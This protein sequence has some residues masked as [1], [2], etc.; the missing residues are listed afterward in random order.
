MRPSAHHCRACLDP[1]SQQRTGQV[2]S[3]PRAPNHTFAKCLSVSAA[4]RTLSWWTA[5]P[6]PPGSS[7]PS[8]PHPHP[9]SISHPV[10][11]RLPAKFSDL[12]TTI[13]LSSCLTSGPWI[14]LVHAHFLPFLFWF[15]S[16]PDDPAGGKGEPASPRF[17]SWSLDSLDHRVCCCH[18]PSRL[19]YFIS[20][21]TSCWA[22]DTP[23]KQVTELLLMAG[24]YVGAR[25]EAIGGEEG[26]TDPFKLP[27]AGEPNWPHCQG[28]NIT[29]LKEGPS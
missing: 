26:Q 7:L 19:C 12:P 14:W 28:A 8:L 17:P 27:G 22:P 15:P 29:K 18:S 16:S 9:N 10:P 20:F 3:Y 6:W 5:W 13:F 24:G 25:V 21:P 1:H 11:L 23:P 4:P 2:L